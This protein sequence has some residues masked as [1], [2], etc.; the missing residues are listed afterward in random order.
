LRVFA[1]NALPAD[2]NAAEAHYKDALL[3]RKF[4]YN[5]N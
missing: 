3:T 1:P 5:R 4:G 2:M